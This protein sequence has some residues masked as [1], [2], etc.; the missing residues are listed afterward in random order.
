MSHTANSTVKAKVET[1]RTRLA[2]RSDEAAVGAEAV[3]ELMLDMMRGE[4]F[5]ALR[6]FR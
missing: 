3:T 6:C 4:P 5:Q 2:A 1:P